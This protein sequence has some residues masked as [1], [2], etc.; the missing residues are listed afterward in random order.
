[1]YIFKHILFAET[2]GLHQMNRDSKQQKQPTASILTLQ[3]SWILQMSPDSAC[4]CFP[5][6]NKTEASQ[7][8]F[9][10]NA[11]LHFNFF[12]LLQADDTILVLS[13]RSFWLEKIKLM[14]G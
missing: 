6:V 8:K 10:W 2:A 11:N 3:M 14:D 4:I 7:D 13:Q 5:Y 12:F 9:E 1:M